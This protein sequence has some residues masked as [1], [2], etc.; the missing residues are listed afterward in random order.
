MAKATVPGLKL[1]GTTGTEETTGTAS[2]S[3]LIALR[4]EETL[5]LHSSSPTTPT[6][7][8]P[9][10][11]PAPAPL[12]PKALRD[13]YL[14]AQG[15]DDAFRRLASLL[16]MATTDSPPG[17]RTALRESGLCDVGRRAAFALIRAAYGDS[18]EGEALAEAQLAAVRAELAGPAPP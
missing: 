7:T 1:A 3:P 13:A 16:R 6:P 4:P 9:T 18:L 15:G 11:P 2:A 17:S 5:P 12:T 14:A 10:S 8:P